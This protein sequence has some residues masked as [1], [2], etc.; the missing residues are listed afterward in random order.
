[1][2]NGTNSGRLASI[3]VNCCQPSRSLLFF[4]TR[5][6]LRWAHLPSSRVLPAFPSR[7][8][9]RS[10]T[11]QFI[12]ARISPARSSVPRC[13][14]GSAYSGHRRAVPSPSV[15]AILRL[16][17]RIPPVFR[18]HPS[19]SFAD[20]P[21]ALRRSLAVM[22]GVRG[23]LKVLC[24]TCA[25]SWNV[26]GLSRY[27]RLFRPTSSCYLYSNSHGR[28]RALVHSAVMLLPLLCLGWDRYPPSFFSR[29]RLS[30]CSRS[31]EIPEI[32]HVEPSGQSRSNC[33]PRNAAGRYSA[34]KSN[35]AFTE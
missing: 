24:S 35:R 22:L 14:R 17:R 27:L 19:Y 2:C 33:T 32:W 25:F 18:S 10:L 12:S 30:W 6:F 13:L 23:F 20:V 4:K 1:M 29:V 15:V 8:C 21:P 7:R 5:P 16:V 11:G 3:L 31:P 28:G 34:T 26:A 9:W